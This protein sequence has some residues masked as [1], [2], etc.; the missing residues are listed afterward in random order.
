MSVQ[1]GGEKRFRLME[2]LGAGAFG[3]IYAGVDT[4]TSMPVAVKL[5]HVDAEHPQLAYEA[6][7]YSQ[8]AGKQGVPRILYTAREGDYNIMVME[9]LGQNLE[10]LLN[11]CNRHFTMPTVLMLADKMLTLLQK[12]HDAGFIHRD[13]KPDN[14]V[15]GGG[16]KTGKSEDELFIIDFGLSKCYLNPETRTHI[17]WRTDKHLTGTARYASINNHKGCEQSRRDDL[18]SVGY[19]LLYLLRGG[20]PWQNKKGNSRKAKYQ[21]MMQHKQQVV[22][23]GSLWA[24]LPSGFHDYFN[25]VQRLE[26]TERPDYMY[27]RNLFRRVYKDAGY[28]PRQPDWSELTQSLSHSG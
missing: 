3:E 27:L 10:T 20:L 7:V 4:R 11:K 18:E 24:E 8:L 6:R 23:D 15:I 28:G 22:G 5:E 9:R 12:V 14:F 21:K 25:Y 1:I 19:V 26:F 2:R 16:G 13:V 17:P